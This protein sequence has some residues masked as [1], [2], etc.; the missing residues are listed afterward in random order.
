MTNTNALSKLYSLREEIENNLAEIKAILGANFPEEYA[1]ASQHWI[2]QILTALK[3][4][5]QYL[6][7]GEY[8][9]D[10]TLHRIEDKMFGGFDK[11]VSKYI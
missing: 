8:S 2:P 10:Y 4:N 7:R 3:N 6:S 11:G 1:T 9:M 5:T